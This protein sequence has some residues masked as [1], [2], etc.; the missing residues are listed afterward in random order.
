[1]ANHTTVSPSNDTK[2]EDIVPSTILL[3]NVCST[4]REALVVHSD[5]L[6]K[7]SGKHSHSLRSSD[8]DKVESLLC[9]IDGT[10][11]AFALVNGAK[12]HLSS[13]GN[14][15]NSDGPLATIGIAI[16]AAH[17]TLDKCVVQGLK[18]DRRHKI[19]PLRMH[20]PA[21]LHSCGQCHRGTRLTGEAVAYTTA[22]L[23]PSNSSSV[24]SSTCAP[25]ATSRH[26]T[27]SRCR[28]R[29]RPPP[30]P[31]AVARTLCRSIL[32]PPRSC[33]LIS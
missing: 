13:I 5:R 20:F 17:D 1:M 32:R 16:A 12:R 25:L 23:S 31:P 7:E 30:C 28:S 27:T 14:V 21:T 11:A 18:W 19:V 8:A 10:D 24:P 26:R 9:F 4:A 3:A 22:R 2:Q 33:R 6:T 15:R 29:R